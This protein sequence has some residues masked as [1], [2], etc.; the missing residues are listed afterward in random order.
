MINLDKAIF[1]PNSA[2]LARLKKYA[3]FCE[4]LSVI[5]LTRKKFEPIRDGNLLVLASASCSR[6]AYLKDAMRLAKKII[7]DQKIDLVMTQDPFDTGMA[8]WLIK[9]KF[10]IPWQ[11][12]AHADFL[13][14]YFWQESFLNKARVLIAKF[15]IPKADGIRVVSERIKNSL[16][17]QI[18]NLLVSKITVLPIFIDIDKFK[19]APIKINLKEKYPQFDFL[20]LMASRLSREKNIGLAI[21]AM[22]DIVK[23]YP[24]TGLIIVGEGTEE[25]TLKSKVG[26]LELSENVIFEPWT[27][28]LTSYYKSA[29]LFLLTSNYEGWG[30]TAIEAA[31]SHCPILMTDVG[32]AGE[33]IKNKKSGLVVPPGDKEALVDSICIL[34]DNKNL[35][36]ELASQAQEMIKN[37]PSEED[38][39]QLYFQSWQKL[40]IN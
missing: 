16:V 29:D 17:S 12:Q 25:K 30:L 23:K 35:R 15:L 36:E 4:K 1:G 26:I 38:Y 18:P 5:V 20:I 7:K 14:S 13:S 40:L 9:K 27:N 39:L 19:N 37:L 2:S 6:P 32:C 11:C 33:I 34:R 21:E 8:G 24:K 31:A 22:V 3:Q 10:K 28:N